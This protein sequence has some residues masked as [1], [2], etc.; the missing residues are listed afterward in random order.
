MPTHSVSSGVSSS[1][2]RWQLPPVTKR[3]RIARARS[4]SASVPSAL[5]AIDMIPWRLVFEYLNLSEILQLTAVSKL[6]KRRVHELNELD[7]SNVIVSAAA[8]T[9]IARNFTQL[10]KLKATFWQAISAQA[11]AMKLSALTL[12]S[13]LAATPRQFELSAL[14]FNLSALRELRL[15]DLALSAVQY[16]ELLGACVNLRRLYVDRGT[17]S[18]SCLVSLPRLVVLNCGSSIRACSSNVV[19]S[20]IWKNV[21]GVED[22]TL[23]AHP[24]LHCTALPTTLRA[25]SVGGRAPPLTLE[26]LRHMCALVRTN[27][28][29]MVSVTGWS[30]HSNKLARRQR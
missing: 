11:T 1:T 23:F 25:L 24:G 17:F 27:C 2:S 22:L 12:V 9:Y 19:W 21:P 5:T 10:S 14:S 28:K 26:Q 7:I 15:Y 30:V 8:C 16:R 4:M 20:K 3:G 29:L 13:P 6:M 18:L